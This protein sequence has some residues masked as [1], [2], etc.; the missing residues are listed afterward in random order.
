M[1]QASLT[2]PDT[3]GCSVRISFSSPVEGPLAMD[4]GMHFGLRL[5][6][7][8]FCPDDI[9]GATSETDRLA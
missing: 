3:L 8:D 2:Q 7:E 6:V 4:F 5:F 9:A 1:G